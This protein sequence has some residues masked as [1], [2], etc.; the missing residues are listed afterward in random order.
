MYVCFV[1]TSS[2][3]RS[4]GKHLNVIHVVE[5]RD[6]TIRLIFGHV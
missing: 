1:T 2:L 4:V 6:L 5:L 3:M